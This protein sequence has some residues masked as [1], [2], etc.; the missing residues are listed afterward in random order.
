MTIKLARVN[1]NQRVEI[2]G[3]PANQLPWLKSLG[4]FTEI[5][6]YQTRVFV[7]ADRAEAILHLILPGT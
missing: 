4:C 5:I 2:V 7:A 6:R 3:A 1:G